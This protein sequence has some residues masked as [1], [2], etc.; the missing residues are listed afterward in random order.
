MLIDQIDRLMI[1]LRLNY[2]SVV[3]IYMIG[4]LH[5]SILNYRMR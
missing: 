2:L 5:H 4:Y 3:S 1:I